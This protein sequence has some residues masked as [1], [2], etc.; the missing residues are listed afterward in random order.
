MNFDGLMNLVSN[1]PVFTSGLLKIAGVKE[2]QITLQLVRWVN[3]GLLVQLRRGL[4]ALASPYRKI[5]PHPFLI[6]NALNRASYVSLQSALAWHGLIP[7]NVPGVTSVTSGRSEQLKTELGAFLFRHCKRELFS[8]FSRIEVVDR[9]QAVVATPEKALVDL[10]YLTPSSAE[11]GYIEELRLQ[12]T[13]K[14]D[15]EALVKWAAL[16]GSEKV[17][18]AVRRLWTAISKG[19]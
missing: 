1:E 15:R 18:R 3:A 8:G 17:P 2:K 16:T 10:L 19:S 4:Y 5:E 11:E 6:A 9:Q 12:N 7:E 14:L 13:G